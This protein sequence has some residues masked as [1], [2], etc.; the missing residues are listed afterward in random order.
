MKLIDSIIGTYS[1]RQIRK[2]TKTVDAIEA[3][4]DRYA[5]MSDSELSA[6]TALFRER[7]ANGAMLDDLLPEAFVKQNGYVRI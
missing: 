2:L 3:L 1:E 5:A 4:A 6:S 7:L